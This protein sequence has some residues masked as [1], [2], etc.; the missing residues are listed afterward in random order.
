[1]DI[2]WLVVDWFALVVDGKPAAP[3]ALF[4]PFFLLVGLVLLFSHR[5]SQL[6]TRKYSTSRWTDTA[7]SID[8]STD[9]FRRNFG[10]GMPGDFGALQ[11]KGLGDS[12]D[13]DAVLLLSAV[14]AADSAHV[15]VVVDSLQ[16]D[17]EG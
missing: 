5:G 8:S 2:G 10:V 16:L 9:T 17:F 12:F 4:A 6:I 7:L 11:S 14:D 1:M 15:L 3:S 13:N